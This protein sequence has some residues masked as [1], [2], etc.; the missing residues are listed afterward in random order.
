VQAGPGA[1]AVAVV[2]DSLTDGRGSTTNGN[3][4]WPDRLFARLQSGPDASRVAVLN[5]GIGG[6][7]VLSDGLGPAALA[8]LDRVMAQNAVK[9]LVVFEGVNDLGTAGPTRTAQQTA[10]QDLISAYR[11]MITRAQALGMLVFGA[12]LTPFGGHATYDDPR[13]RREA[14][15]QAVNDWIRSGQR[16]DAVLDFDRAVR[17]PACPRRLRA[18]YDSGDHL[19]LSPAGYQ[20]LADAVPA[21]LFAAPPAAAGP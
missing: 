10:A 5:Q 19:H 3:D 14:A 8:R 15:R 1:A 20:A 17:D 13:G 6:N 12:T 4:R 7:R 18:G 11:L 2:G 16:F 21:V 9:W